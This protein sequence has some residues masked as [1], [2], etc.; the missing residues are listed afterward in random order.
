MASIGYCSLCEREVGVVKEPFG[1]LFWLCILLGVVTPL[2]PITLPFF[3]L[4]AFGVSL[5]R[6]RI[7]GLCSSPLRKND[8]NFG[9]VIE[10][11]QA[12]QSSAKK[13]V[14]GTDG[15]IEGDESD[16]LPQARDSVIQLDDGQTKMDADR[17][18][19]NAADWENG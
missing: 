5:S 1:C 18:R 17:K 12:I 11:T 8:G 15:A 9:Q 7:C 16:A 4:I 19:R 6:K 10:Q 3:W 13:T 14:L 2:W